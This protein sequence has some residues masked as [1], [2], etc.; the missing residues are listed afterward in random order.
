MGTACAGLATAGRGLWACGG[1]LK[2]LCRVLTIRNRL[3]NG[4]NIRGV[5]CVRCVGDAVT[6]IPV[7]VAAEI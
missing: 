4:G 2:N 7:A 6:A 5:G 1:G 3:L